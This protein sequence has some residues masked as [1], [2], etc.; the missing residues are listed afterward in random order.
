MKIIPDKN[1]KIFI[2]ISDNDDFT[3]LH[4][5]NI[6]IRSN[7]ESL[8]N[9]KEGFIQ[10]Y[11]ENK[12]SEQDKRFEKLSEDKF[13]EIQDT[14]LELLNTIEGFGL[15]SLRELYDYSDYICR[16]ATYSQI[17]KAIKKN[18]KIKK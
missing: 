6:T 18:I 12:R 13:N 1:E 15:K 17:S 8:E 10:R 4:F 16:K 11:L 5:E 9:L 3:N 2:D 7:A 14:I